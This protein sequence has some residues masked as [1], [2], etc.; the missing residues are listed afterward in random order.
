M[1]VAR[2]SSSQEILIRL[3]SEDQFSRTEREEASR[4]GAERVRIW[5]VL[6]VGACARIGIVGGERL[7]R[8]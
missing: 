1:S 5:E 6:R 2:A 3:G 8:S 4:W 7:C